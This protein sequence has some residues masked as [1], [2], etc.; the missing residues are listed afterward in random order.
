MKHAEKVAPVAAAA[1]ALATLACC[2]PLGI[3]AAAAT[4]SLGA[5]LSEYRP[6]LLAASAALLIVGVVQL[7]RVQRACATRQNRGSVVVLALSAT[8]VI[9]VALF[10]QVVA[11]L[12]ADWM[13]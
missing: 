4:A 1:S 3:A 12:V 6:W 9:L 7:L 13:P 2:L 11:G 5:V 10:P 8:I